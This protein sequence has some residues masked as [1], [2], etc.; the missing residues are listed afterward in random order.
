MNKIRIFQR[1]CFYSEGRVAKKDAR[2]INFTLEKC[3]E[4]L[5]KTTQDH[6]DIVEIV[7]LLD[8]KHRKGKKHFLEENPDNIIIEFSGGT[9]A[10]SFNFLLDYMSSIK[11]GGDDI[12]Y[13]LEDDYL[14]A[15][16]WVN[17][18]L[19]AFATIPGIDYLTLYDHNDKYGLL[20]MYDKLTSKIYVSNYCHWRVVPNTTNTYAM[21]FST[22]L[23]SIVIHRKYSKPE[24]LW[25]R[26]AEKFADLT[27]RGYTLVSPM[28]GFST[29]VE[30]PYM[31]PC[32]DW[33]FYIEDN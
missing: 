25:T 18:M 31:S 2:P 4:N 20:P 16:D 8:V 32:I 1:H 17:V 30:N 6:K 13:F 29:H 23:N 33:D 21:R 5:L 12:V 24:L 7:Y 28:P 14:H 3:N 9:D 26:D 15:Y 11:L 19:D 10:I 22:L 27:S